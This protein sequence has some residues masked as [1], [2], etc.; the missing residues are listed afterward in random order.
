MTVAE[1]DHTKSYPNRDSQQARLGR[2]V[3][4]DSLQPATHLYRNK[5]GPFN[6]MT[7]NSHKPDLIVTN[8]RVILQ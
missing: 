5:A 2:F 4:S 7:Q 3:G 6:D 1:K 8:T